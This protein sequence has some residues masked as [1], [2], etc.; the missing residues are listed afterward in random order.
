[1]KRPLPVEGLLWRRVARVGHVKVAALR[2]LGLDGDDGRAAAAL[3]GLRVVAGVGE[4]IAQ[5]GDE[6][7]A[8]AALVA[9]HVL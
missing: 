5:R 8:E 6:E 3:G 4:E 2:L 7:G 9:I 1:M